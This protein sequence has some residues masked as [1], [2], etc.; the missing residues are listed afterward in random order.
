MY[1]ARGRDR[2][3][4]EPEGRWMTDDKE[5]LARIRTL[6][7]GAESV[8]REAQS[9]SEEVGSL[10]R[11]IPRLFNRLIEDIGDLAEEVDAIGGFMGQLEQAGEGVGVT[12]E[13]SRD[14]PDV[15]AERMHEEAER[16]KEAFADV[17]GEQYEP[18]T[19]E[20]GAVG[21]EEA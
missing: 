5:R 2:V 10:S 11:W 6:L 18:P 16:A 9:L 21:R 8:I 19:Q 7:G 1:Y 3:A 12:M 4:L 14:E 13:A 17:A 15:M 20:P